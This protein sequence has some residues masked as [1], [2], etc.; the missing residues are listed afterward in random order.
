MEI[1]NEKINQ[2]IK[3]LAQENELD[4]VVLFG[5][6][7]KGNAIKESDIDIGIFRKTGGLTFDDQI[8]LNHKFAELFKNI[9]IDVN[10]ISPNNPVLMFSILKYGK[11]LFTTENKIVDTLRLYAWKL[12]MESK[13][14]RDHSF[15]LLKNRIMSLN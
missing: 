9:N 3:K 2:Q 15:S 13:N 14:F 11:I 8:V 1:V 10:I 4:L 12:M 7:A 6:F 5:S